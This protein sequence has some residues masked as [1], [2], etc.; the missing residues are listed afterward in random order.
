MYVKYVASNAKGGVSC[1]LGEKTLIVGPNGS[2]KSS[3]INAIELALAGFASDIAGREEVAKESELLA[4][5]P[6]RKGELFA[7]AVLSDNTEAKWH[8]GQKGAKKAVHNVPPSVI[9]DRVFPFRPVREAV[10]GKPD[11]ARK[12]FINFAIPTLSREDVFARI[13]QGLH[14]HYLNAILS[15]DM[16]MAEV[17]KLL[18]AL[19][20]A[21][22]MARDSKKKAKG[23]T[24]VV[25][26]VTDG[27]AP[28]PTEEVQKALKKELT[29][30]QKAIDALAQMHGAAAQSARLMGEAQGIRAQLQQ[31]EANVAQLQQVL[32]QAEAVLA[33]TPAPASVDAMTQSIIAIIEK[34]AALEQSLGHPQT[35]PLC[36]TQMPHGTFVQR[37][38]AA[39]AFLANEQ[40]KS[41]PY[42]LAKTQVQTHQS[43][44]VAWQAQ[45]QSLRAQLDAL[46]NSIAAGTVTLPTAEQTEIAQARLKKASDEVT[47]VETL[48]AQWEQAKKAKEVAKDTEKSEDHWA[49][50]AEACNT[51]VK[52][53][54][55][56]GVDRFVSL[57]Q[58]FLPEADRFSLRLHEDQKGVFRFGLLRNGVLHTALSGAEWAR[59][60]GAIAGACQNDPSKLSVL[61]PEE[62]AFDGA[63]LYNTLE[64]LSKVP[65]QIVIAAP[66]LP[67]KDGQYAVPAG[68]TL[69]RTD[70]NQHRTAPPPENAKAA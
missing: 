29:D 3:I 62:R 5:A 69:V 61:I 13:P 16:Q 54:L 40:G 4:L 12:F 44:L 36:K 17:D 57:V 1:A 26:A 18:L 33:Q 20:K 31:A 35:C 68:W 52:E 55:D 66:N 58:S 8:A 45:V 21:T 70:T 25:Q 22:K 41:G 19:E 60:M 64:A 23:Q 28:L 39:Q 67:V 10:R 37:H 49:E 11:T 48:K 51:A 7:R 6:E 53:L 43:N 32:Q 46:Q 24:E 14:Q 38:Q 63:T 30:A 47:R 59:V 34:L 15:A 2:G 9:P 50:L 27:L 65:G 56:A 42:S